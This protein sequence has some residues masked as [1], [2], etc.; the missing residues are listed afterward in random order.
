MSLYYAQ[1]DWP[2]DQPCGSFHDDGLPLPLNFTSAALDAVAGGT[3][4]VPSFVTDV[5]PP[6]S[7]GA[8][9]ALA[10]RE[11]VSP[12][13][14]LWTNRASASPRYSTFSPYRVSLIILSLRVC[15]CALYVGTCIALPRRSRLTVTQ[16]A[17]IRHTSRLDDCISV[18]R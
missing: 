6:V 10:R 15:F 5:T 4:A 17:N 14:S 1:A 12:R 18:V 2:G 3:T 9:Q 16:L 7:H 13:F 8:D 11:R